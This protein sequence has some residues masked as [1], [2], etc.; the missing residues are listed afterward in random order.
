MYKQLYYVINHERMI[1]LN[2]LWKVKH[3]HEK[4]FLIKKKS[5]SIKIKIYEVLLYYKDKATDWKY[6]FMFKSY[7]ISVFMKR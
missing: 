1:L 7:Q 2:A 3:S 5:C 4:K 6:K